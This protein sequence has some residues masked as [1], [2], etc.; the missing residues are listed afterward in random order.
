MRPTGGG[1][2]FPAGND[3]FATGFVR[4]QKQTEENVVIVVVQLNRETPS[5]A[6]R[7]FMRGGGAG[8]QVILGCTP[9]VA[10]LRSP[11]FTDHNPG[12][13]W[14]DGEPVS[15]ADAIEP[16]APRDWIV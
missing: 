9:V 11:F 8:V 4:Q 3:V 7:H 16:E 5:V 6:V 14:N 13:S 1:S 15:H 2:K 12:C 10:S